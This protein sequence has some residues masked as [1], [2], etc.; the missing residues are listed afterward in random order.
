[1][2]IIDPHWNL[3]LPFGTWFKQYERGQDEGALPPTR[4]AYILICVKYATQCETR[5]ILV[6]NIPV[7]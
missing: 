7:A 1:M 4:G 5:A 6:E 2:A 3:F